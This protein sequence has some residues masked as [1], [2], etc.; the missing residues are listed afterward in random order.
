MPKI[1]TWDT[2]IWGALWKPMSEN[3]DMGH[4]VVFL[5]E[6]YPAVGEKAVRH[7]LI[8][9]EERLIPIIASPAV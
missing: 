8:P 5:P 6:E 3:P 7:G 9:I 2:Q 1:Q 4:P